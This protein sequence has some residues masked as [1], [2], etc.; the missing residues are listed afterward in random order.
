MA[1]EN[2]QRNTGQPRNYKMDRGGM[3]TEMGP[4]IGIVKNN[5]DPTR[6]GRLQVYIELFGGA[7]PNNSSLWRTVN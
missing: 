7:D 1:G 4:F 6:S 3:P 2:I 5:V